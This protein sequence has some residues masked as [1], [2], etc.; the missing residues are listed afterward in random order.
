MRYFQLLFTGIMFSCL[1]FGQI[2][3]NTDFKVTRCISTSV[4]KKTKEGGKQIIVADISTSKLFENVSCELTAS[5]SG[6]K[7]SYSWGSL[8]KGKKQLILEIPVVDKTTNFK[9]RF[10]SENN[11]IAEG[12]AVCNP[13]RK[14]KIYDIQV[15]HH[16]LG[17][18]DYYH[19]MRRDVR[20]YG[21]E[22]GLDFCRKTD[23]LDDNCKFR[24][25]VETSEPM[26]RFIS[27]QKPE[28][29]KELTERIMQGR[30]ELGALHNSV[31]TEQMGYEL[32]SRLFYTPNRYVR[33][34]LHI[35]PAQT[36]LIDDIVGYFQVQGLPKY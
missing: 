1:T 6:S 33:D 36:A 10:K 16:D 25:T 13:P 28:I 5:S 35:D 15:S 2:P 8:E 30:I 31:Y 9:Y 18:A 20:E 23:N 34:L 29:I 26:T 4:V 12:D 7:T 19:F 32:M 3:Q 22:M 17:Y 24:W 14:W 11:Q 27:S 21:I